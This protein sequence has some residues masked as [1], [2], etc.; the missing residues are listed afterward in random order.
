MYPRCTPGTKIGR[1]PRR[2]TGL[3]AAIY[4]NAGGGTRTPDTRIMIPMRFGSTM[5]FAGAGGQKRGHNRAAGAESEPTEAPGPV[6]EAGILPWVGARSVP[7]SRSC[8]RVPGRGSDAGRR[9]ERCGRARQLRGWGR[10]RLDREHRAERVNDVAAGFRVGP[11][12]A[13]RA[14]DDR[15]ARGEPTG[16]RVFVDDGDV[17]RILW[18]GHACS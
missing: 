16:S 5:P 12:R 8:G 15:D 17:D 7:G 4:R 9:P 13:D 11:P 14:R 2:E 10:S 1:S 3:F 18:L 6:N